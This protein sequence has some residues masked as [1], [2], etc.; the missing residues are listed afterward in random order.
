[1]KLKFLSLEK[2]WMEDNINEIYNYYLINDE[3][4]NYITTLRDLRLMSSA[5]GS[6]KRAELKTNILLKMINDIITEYSNI[7]DFMQRK[8]I[9]KCDREEISR[10]ELRFWASLKA[11]H[12]YKRSMLYI[13]VSICY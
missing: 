5:I 4:I 11:K 3:I 10:D 6:K 7:N 1:M 8:L 12:F 9:E 2:T 13:K